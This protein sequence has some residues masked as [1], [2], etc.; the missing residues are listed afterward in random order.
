MTRVDAHL[1]REAV[2]PACSHPIAVPFLIDEQPLAT[3]AWPASEKEAKQLRPLPLDFLRCVDCGHVYNAAFDY[4]EVPYSAKPNLMFNRG[5]NWA[6]FLRGVQRD[7]LRRVPEEPVVV[8]IGHGDGSFLAAL[9]EQRPDGRFVGFDPNGAAVAPDGSGVELRAEFF[10]P[11]RHLEEL[12]PD[13]IVSRHVMEHLSNPLGFLQRISFAASCVGQSPLVYLEVPCI[14]RVL[15]TGRTVDLY[16][17]HNSHFT[18]ESFRRMLQ[19]CAPAGATIGHGYDGEV[20]FGVVHLG[21]VSWHLRTAREASRYRERAAEAQATIAA[22]LQALLDADR[23]VA[24]WGGTGKSA[25]FINRYGLDARRFP[26]V[27]DSDVAKV[28]TYVPGTGQRIEARERLLDGAADVVII[29]PQWRACDIVEEMAAAGIHPRTVLIE[30]GGRLIDFFSDPHSYR[31]DAA[32][33][34]RPLPAVA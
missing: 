16:Y 24:I 27:V 32:R 12:Q 30:D 23:R 7:L 17:E 20:V 25:A 8:E 1:A 31:T 19:R 29:P 6:S 3:I 11:G 18:T 10:D 21:D 26:L 4:A 9:A 15:E 22:Q 28:G 13:L 14:D 5:S 2:C 33:Q 34:P